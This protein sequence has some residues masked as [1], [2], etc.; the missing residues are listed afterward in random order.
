M[1]VLRLVPGGYNIDDGRRERLREE[2]FNLVRI[3][4]RIRP[5]PTLLGQLLTMGSELP[6]YGY[7]PPVPSGQPTGI[8]SGQPSGQP[9]GQP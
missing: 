7:S 6:P 4:E 3:E 5:V 9:T 1:N 8:P 2:I